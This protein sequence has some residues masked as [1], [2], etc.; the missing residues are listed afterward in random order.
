MRFIGTNVLL[1]VSEGHPKHEMLNSQD[2]STFIE[3]GT[4]PDKFAEQ[5][6]SDIK[7]NKY[8]VVKSESAQNN[9]QLSMAQQVM[10]QKI[11]G[12]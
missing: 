2:S 9:Q 1:E 4:Y 3:R 11:T 10:N 7:E 12:R 5:L 8:D 6:L